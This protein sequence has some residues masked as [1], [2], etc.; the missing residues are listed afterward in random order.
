ML[1]SDFKVLG[2]KNEQW[3]S[4]KICQ[5]KVLQLFTNSN[6]RIIR[7][8]CYRGALAASHQLF[9][10]DLFPDHHFKTST[11]TFR[12]TLEDA[13]QIYLEVTYL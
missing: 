4:K 6:S 7:H 11:L 9:H 13:S 10:N 2:D 8:K 3:M 12:L 5:L 1:S